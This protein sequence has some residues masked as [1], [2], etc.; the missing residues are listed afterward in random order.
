MLEGH[1]VMAFIGQLDQENSGVAE[2]GDFAQGLQ[3]SRTTIARVG[4]FGDTVDDVS[5]FLAQF[6]G[7][8]LAD[9]V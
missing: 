3:L 4:K 9:A 2:H 5:D 6:T 8:F 1:D 7:K